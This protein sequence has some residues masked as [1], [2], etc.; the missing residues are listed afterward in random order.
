[1]MRAIRL[2][3]RKVYWPLKPQRQGLDTR[4]PIR[5]DELSKS[6]VWSRLAKHV[7]RSRPRFLAL[8]GLSFHVL[9]IFTR[10]VFAHGMYPVGLDEAPEFDRDWAIPNVSDARGM[11]VAEFTT[12]KT[13]RLHR[14]A[15]E[16]HHPSPRIIAILHGFKHCLLPRLRKTP[17]CCR[18]ISG[19][20]FFRAPTASLSVD[21]RRTTP[22][23]S[24]ILPCYSRRSI[25]RDRQC[26]VA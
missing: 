7:L 2:G 20:Y 23:N 18:Q 22:G 9:N 11:Q 4:P 10:S 13:A 5:F 15:S 21:V 16:H 6:P 1:M 19:G 26:S 17:A 24:T 12:T 14:A 3:S 25:V 8:L